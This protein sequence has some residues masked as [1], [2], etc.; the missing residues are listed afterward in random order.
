VSA[1]TALFECSAFQP[2]Q[3]FACFRVAWCTGGYFRKAR[4]AILGLSVLYPDL[5]AA[6]VQEFATRDEFKAWLPSA[7]EVLRLCAFVAIG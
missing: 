7:H 2:S 6:D 5:V 3:L 4:D 1:L